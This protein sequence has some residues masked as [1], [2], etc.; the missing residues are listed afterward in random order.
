MNN[1]KFPVTET[2]TFKSKDSPFLRLVFDGVTV[3]LNLPTA[4]EKLYGLPDSGKGLT[5]IVLLPAETL[6]LSSTS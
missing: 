2:A 4:P 1:F 3:K 6:L 5:V